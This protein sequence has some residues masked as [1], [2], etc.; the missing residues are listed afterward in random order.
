VRDFRP[1]GFAVG[2]RLRLDPDHD[3][4]RVRDDVL[5]WLVEHYAFERRDFGRGVSQSELAR[6]IHAIDGVIGVHLERLHRAGES[7]TLVSFLPA[8]VPRA[9]G[10][11]QA[12]GAEILTLAPD[13]AQLE[14]DW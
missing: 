8:D 1:A 12:D 7:G 5:A 14:V 3:P 13:D 11:P 9:G 4:D 10:S 2:A 6:A